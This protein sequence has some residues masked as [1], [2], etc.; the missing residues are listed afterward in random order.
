[1]YYVF[2]V[3]CINMWKCSINLNVIGLKFPVL[4][5]CQPFLMQ[6]SSANYWSH[7]QSLFPSLHALPRECLHFCLASITSSLRSLLGAKQVFQGSS[8]LERGNIEIKWTGAVT[9]LTDYQRCLFLQ[10]EQ[11]ICTEMDSKSRPTL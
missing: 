8:D 1:M 4:T 5:H 10:Y 9:W 7:L 6:V 2:A 3:Q 11:V